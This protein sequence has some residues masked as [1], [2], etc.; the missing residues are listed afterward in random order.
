MV[1]STDFSEE[2]NLT[3]YSIFFITKYPIVATC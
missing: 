2:T 3:A 1:Q